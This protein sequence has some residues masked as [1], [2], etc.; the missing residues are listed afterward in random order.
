MN[1]IP[2][3]LRFYRSHAFAGWVVTYVC[4][5]LFRDM[6]LM[7]LLPMLFLKLITQFLILYFVSVGK[8][9]E[10]FFYYNLQLSFKNLLIFSLGIDTAIFI[11][12][13]LIISKL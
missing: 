11:L 1:Q 5:R 12:A 13:L 7:V 9:K 8:K 2:L 3:L 4:A 6:G 10:L